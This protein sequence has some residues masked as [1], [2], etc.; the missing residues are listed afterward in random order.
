MTDM[1]PVQKFRLGDRV[2]SL[3]GDTPFVIDAVC[4]LGG[5]V[6][7]RGLEWAWVLSDYLTLAPERPPYVA[8]ERRL[9]SRKG[10]GD[11]TSEYVTW[12]RPETD[13]ELAARNAVERAAYDRL[14]ADDA[15]IYNASGQIIG[16][17]G[18]AGQPGLGADNRQVCDYPICS[19]RGAGHPLACKCR[20]A[21]P[22]A[23][24]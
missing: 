17:T 5:R 21:T 1:T 19:T 2:R 10:N 4:L 7:Y 18:R 22:K 8:S 15:V 13:A 9:I 14:N 12:H 6:M 3:M 16:I 24:P 20:T 11:S 23:A